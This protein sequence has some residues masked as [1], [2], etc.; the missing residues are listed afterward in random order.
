MAATTIQADS[1]NATSTYIDIDALTSDDFSPY[2]HANNLVLATN[3]PSDPTIDLTTP[4]SRVLFDLQEIDSHIHTLTARSALDILTY[5]ASQNAAAQRILTRIEEERARLNASYERLE[6]EILVRHQKAV[7]AKTTAQRSWEVLRLG[8]GVQRILNLARQFEVIL[9]E[10]GLGGGARVGKED[11]GALV[12]ASHSI[13]GFRDVIT[14]KEGADLARVNLVKTLRGRVF[15]DGEA[16]ILDF[17]RRTVREFSMSTLSSGP[18]GGVSTTSGPTYREVEDSRARFTSAVH[19]LYLLSPAPRID[20]E[21]MKKKDFE[22]EY[23][24]RALQG[25]LQTAITSSSA[26]IGRA[27]GQLPT[28]DR[29][30][31]ETSARC[32][33]IVALE[34]TLRGISAPDHP[35]LQV[36]ALDDKKVTSVD[37]DKESDEEE[38]EN[39]EP[40]QTAPSDNF[41][42]L[43]LSA[44]DTAS[45]PSYF[46]RSLASSLSTRVQE[47]LTRGGVSARTLRSQ[48]DAV[49]QEIRECVLRGSKLPRTVLAADSKA[50]ST[51]KGE[52]EVENW[53][54]EAAVMVG[55]VVGLLGR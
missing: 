23:L 17:A 51:A 28:L 36:E 12:R 43:L 8:R 9:A 22:P 29:A 6:K 25:Y 15:E 26:S 16:R 41:L 18:G 2:T 30:L 33:N 53:E 7:D 4:L 49:R 50:M 40:S 20:G 27:L 44:L 54:R 11:H 1:G 32:Q 21:K 24:L 5:T 34:A 55:S 3:N 39:P 45:L 31:L 48:R 19:I 38:D 52:Q 37:D 47:I 46:W 14:G 10:S 13:L 35:L 42:S